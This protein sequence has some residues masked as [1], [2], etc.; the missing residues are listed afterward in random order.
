MPRFI[1]VLCY[2]PALEQLNVLSSTTIVLLVVKHCGLFLLDSGKWK[3]GG[4]YEYDK[5]LVL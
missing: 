5:G 4:G 1:Y 2:L 3:V